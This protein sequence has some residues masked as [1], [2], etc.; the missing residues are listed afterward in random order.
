MEVTVL[1]GNLA[2]GICA[3][4]I[5]LT[6]S[7]AYARVQVGG[8]AAFAGEANTIA[9]GGSS[10]SS[11]YDAFAYLTPYSKW[12][13]YVGLEYVASS[14]TGPNSAGVNSVFSTDNAALGLRYTF[15]KSEVFYVGGAF[16][17][18]ANASYQTTGAA[19]E[20]WT[21]SSM[22]FQ[23]GLRPELNKK[24]RVKAAVHYV[25]STYSSKKTANAASS[26]SAVN[27]F[28]RTSYFPT[29]GIEYCF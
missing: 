2:R 23:A 26:S 24:W 19:A 14:F 25:S 1:R 8:S 11:Y 27:S 22:I 18:A 16:A 7:H 12:N 3:V 9:S 13:L 15:G 28:T 10:D 21:G 29:L 17:L 20:T 5:L 6:S 4:L